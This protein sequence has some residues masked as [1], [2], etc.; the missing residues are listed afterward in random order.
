[1]IPEQPDPAA[2]ADLVILRLRSHEGS[3][4]WRSQTARGM[5]RAH[6]IVS[7]ASHVTDEIRLEDVPALLDA[8]DGRILQGAK[9]V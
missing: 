4:A 3:Q 1:M 5:L 2:L 6:R 7:A 8:V 9:G